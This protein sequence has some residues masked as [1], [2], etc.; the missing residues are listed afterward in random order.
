MLSTSSLLALYKLYAAQICAKKSNRAHDCT[1][2]SGITAKPG[3]SQ[4]C[5][6]WAD[7]N[8]F[9]YDDVR[10][11]TSMLL[12]LLNMSKATLGSVQIFL[13]RCPMDITGT[14]TGTGSMA[15]V[16]CG[17]VSTAKKSAGFSRRRVPVA[18]TTKQNTARTR[19]TRGMYYSL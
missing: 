18:D 11:N 19:A 13:A 2:R 12:W 14:G 17:N 7:Q 16:T 1:E 8:K 9:T 15:S 4:E 3:S 6:S 5:S 10:L